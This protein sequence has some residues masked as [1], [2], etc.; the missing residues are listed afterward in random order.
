MRKS[1]LTIYSIYDDE[2][3]MMFTGNRYECMEYLNCCERT[4]DNSLY[5]KT[6]IKRKYSVFSTNY[7]EYFKNIKT[8]SKCGKNKEIE[9]FFKKNGYYS[10]ICRECNNEYHRNYRRLKNG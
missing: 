1:L 7:K 6:K 4:F 5:K 3:N 10:S 2:E 8:C 9:Q